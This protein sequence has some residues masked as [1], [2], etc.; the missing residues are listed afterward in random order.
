MTDRQCFLAPLC[1]PEKILPPPFGHLKNLGTPLCHPT[2]ILPP[3]LHPRK[4]LAPL[5]VPPKNMGPPPKYRASP[6]P[7]SIINDTFHGKKKLVTPYRRET[8][9]G[10]PFEQKKTGPA[11]RLPKIFF[12][13]ISHKQM[14]PPP[15]KKL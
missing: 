11:R 5:R 10:T 1:A 3:L 6:H 13:P 2:K 14:P 15:R 7:Q 12:G 8:N 9:S 4:N